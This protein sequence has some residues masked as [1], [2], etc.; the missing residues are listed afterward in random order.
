MSRHAIDSCTLAA[1][2]S[3]CKTSLHVKA[4]V[5]YR[6]SEPPTYCKFAQSTTERVEVFLIPT[7]HHALLRL[8][9]FM[10]D[11]DRYIRLKPGR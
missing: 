1:L 3:A 5:S 2:R 10:F 8:L 7:S 4:G 6:K 11:Q 9:S